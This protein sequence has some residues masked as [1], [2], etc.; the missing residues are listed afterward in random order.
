[1]TGWTE[2]L[3][4][5]YDAALGH[6]ARGLDVSR[7][8]GQSLVLADLFAASAYA[9]MWLGR[10]DEAEAYARDALE[11]ASLVGSSEPRSLADVVSA[12]V[13]MWRGD[14]PRH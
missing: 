10:L 6:L 4:E 9:Y 7:R 11:A 12:A 3:H 8:T 1:M 2:M 5:R 13:V 14:S